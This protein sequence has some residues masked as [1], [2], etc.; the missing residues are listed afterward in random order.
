MC[1]FS[2]RF[3]KSI[4]YSENFENLNKIRSGIQ[5]WERHGDREKRCV[6]TSEGQGELSQWSCRRPPRVMAVLG[7]SAQVDYVMAE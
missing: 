4:L 6:E 5:Q 7:I 1:S 3:Q 2:V